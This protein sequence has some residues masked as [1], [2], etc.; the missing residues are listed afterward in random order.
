M[1][2]DLGSDADAGVVV[3]AHAETLLQAVAAAVERAGQ[4]AQVTVVFCQDV[5]RA[6]AVLTEIWERGG[7]GIPVLGLVERDDGAPVLTP[8]ARDLLKDPRLHDLAVAVPTFDDERTRRILWDQLRAERIEER[9]QLVE[10]DGR[11]APAAAG[12]LPALAA[13]AAGI[14]AGRMAAADRTWS[15][16]QP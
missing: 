8:G 13:A 6:V 10:V 16:L 9:H 15:R 1:S 2:S 12:G 7:R 4:G 5:E 11:T 14:L 3:T